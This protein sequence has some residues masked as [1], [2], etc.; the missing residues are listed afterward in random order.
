MKSI[1]EKDS[2]YAWTQCCKGTPSFA[3]NRQEEPRE[4]RQGNWK[5]AWPQ[6][7][8]C[9][10]QKVCAITNS[11]FEETNEEG[12]EDVWAKRMQEGAKDRKVLTPPRKKGRKQSRRRCQKASEKRRQR[13]SRATGRV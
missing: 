12:R 1:A 6:K 2:D 3:P 8:K 7:V 9:N 4:D 13:S 11:P 10:G 5:Q